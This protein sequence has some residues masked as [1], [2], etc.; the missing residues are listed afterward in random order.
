MA[1]SGSMTAAYELQIQ[2]YE[3]AI[4]KAHSAYPGDWCKSGKDALDSLAKGERVTVAR[5]DLHEVRELWKGMKE[6]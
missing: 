6:S 3:L 1:Q 2:D 4:V 5:V